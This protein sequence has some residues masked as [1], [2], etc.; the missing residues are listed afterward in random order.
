VSAA[1]IGGTVYVLTAAAVIAVIAALVVVDQLL[2]A[3]GRASI[4]RRLR[5]GQRTRL[6]LLW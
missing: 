3:T 5:R 4:W 2:V 6:P 1:G